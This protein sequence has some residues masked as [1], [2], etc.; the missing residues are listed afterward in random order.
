ML[1][2]SQLVHHKK[3]QEKIEEIRDKL[4]SKIR[5]LDTKLSKLNRLIYDLDFVDLIHNGIAINQ[6]LS[7]R[8]IFYKAIESGKCAH[9]YLNAH[10]KRDW[11]VSEEQASYTDQFNIKDF[12]TKCEAIA[13]ALDFVTI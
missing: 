1:T 4:I 2:N 11:R 13:H 12:D 10:N 8:S 6:H 5:K 3:Q 9:V 7:Y